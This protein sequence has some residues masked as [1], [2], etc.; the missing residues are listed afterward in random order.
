[1]SGQGDDLRTYSMAPVESNYMPGEPGYSGLSISPYTR[2]PAVTSFVSYPSP[3]TQPHASNDEASSRWPVQVKA[4]ASCN[5]VPQM[6]H[7]EQCV[8][9]Q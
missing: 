3:L 2:T 6:L 8:R 9:M 5:A 7:E 4:P 1:M